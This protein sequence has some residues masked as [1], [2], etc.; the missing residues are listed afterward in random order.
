MSA[1]LDILVDYVVN[2]SFL[3]FLTWIA[4]FIFIT[5]M[6][7]STTGKIPATGFWFNTLYIFGLI[8]Y[9][10]YGIFTPL[11]SIVVINVVIIYFNGKAILK[12]YVRKQMGIGVVELLLITL[13]EIRRKSRGSRKKYGCYSL[14]LVEKWIGGKLKGSEETYMR[15][16]MK[17]CHCCQKGWDLFYDLVLPLKRHELVKLDI[18]KRPNFREPRR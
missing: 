12:W 16:H 13:F 18:D 3:E 11:W 14:N 17:K 5:A 8:L 2:M 9:C 6:A 10:T 7:L 4:N 15:V 1:L